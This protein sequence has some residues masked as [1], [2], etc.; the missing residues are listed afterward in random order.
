M[1]YAAV[2]ENVSAVNVCVMLMMTAI[3]LGNTV[4]NVP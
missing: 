1:K 4:K 3:T 2:T